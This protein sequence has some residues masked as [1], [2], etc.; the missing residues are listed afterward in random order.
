M[1]YLL[2]AGR[3]PIASAFLAADGKML[4]TWGKDTQLRIW[5]QPSGKELRALQ[6]KRFEGAVASALSPDGKLLAL[7]GGLIDTQTGEVVHGLRPAQG[8]ALAAFSPDGKLLATEGNRGIVLSEVA[9]G[10]VVRPIR[11]AE[12]RKGIQSERITG[13]TFS[14]DGRLLG[15]TILIEGGMIPGSRGEVWEVATGKQLGTPAGVARALN[16]LTFSP[17]GS[18]LAGGHRGYP[19]EHTFTLWPIGKV[20]EKKLLPA[21]GVH[22]LA[23]AFSPD[24]KT[25]ATGTH[26]PRVQ[27]WDVEGKLRAT[28]LPLPRGLEGTPSIDWVTYLDFRKPS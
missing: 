21:G 26:G 2:G 13:V 5:H 6:L 9:T 4:V 16:A 8:R 23:V 17:D 24:G 12:G 1:R 20:G 27:L 7:G 25:V 14:P 15:V 11:P 3:I 10:K 19:P 18:L 22:G 28:L